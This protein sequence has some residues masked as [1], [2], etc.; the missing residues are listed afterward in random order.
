MPPFAYDGEFEEAR[1]CGK[2]TENSQQGIV[3]EGVHHRT[4]VFEGDGS[5]SL[6]AGGRNARGF[7][8]SSDPKTALTLEDG[9]DRWVARG[10][11]EK[12]LWGDRGSLRG[13]GNKASGL[14]EVRTRKMRAPAGRGKIRRVKRKIGTRKHEG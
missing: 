4:R 2:V 3:R 1:D 10:R 11:R 12:C 6:C 13:R 7:F 14:G 5:Y 8:E 9:R